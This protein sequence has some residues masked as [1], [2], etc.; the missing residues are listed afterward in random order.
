MEDLRKHKD[1]KSEDHRSIP[2][3]VG[4]KGFQSEFRPLFTSVFKDAKKLS[5]FR[6][7]EWEE[8]EDNAFADFSYVPEGG[9]IR[10]EMGGNPLW[11]EHKNDLSI[12][13]GGAL[14][15]VPNDYEPVGTNFSMSS[16]QEFQE[17]LYKKRRFK[18]EN[19]S[20]VLKRNIV[21]P[22]DTD[23]SFYAKFGDYIPPKP[24]ISI[25]NTPEQQPKYQADELI[26]DSHINLSY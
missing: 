25:Y 20:N 16:F 23:P 19:L 13:Y 7:Q 3:N 2:K 4:R 14:Y 22:N 12:R 6:S 9:D 5:Q 21:V 24:S 11:N 1:V 17:P 15:T 26:M 10:N 18:R 8:Y